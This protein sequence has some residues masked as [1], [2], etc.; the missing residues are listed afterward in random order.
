MMDYCVSKNRVLVGATR[1]SIQNELSKFF[2]ME[3]ER[4]FPIR[5]MRTDASSE[6][7]AEVEELKRDIVHRYP[8][9]IAHIPWVRQWC[10]CDPLSKEGLFI[11]FI[12]V[13]FT[14]FAEKAFFNSIL[15]GFPPA[16]PKAVNSHEMAFFVVKLS[17][18]KL[19]NDV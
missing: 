17:I 19:R 12:E 11:V 6:K 4:N 8:V 15:E 7:V 14:R 3:P 16:M 10:C 1:V 18:Q 2:L 5:G 13:L 9:D